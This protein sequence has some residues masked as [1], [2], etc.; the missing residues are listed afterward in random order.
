MAEYIYTN[1]SPPTRVLISA[2]LTLSKWS[3]SLLHKKI[4]KHW[5]RG[6]WQYCYYLQLCDHIS[7]ITLVNKKIQTFCGENSCML[8]AWFSFANLFENKHLI[9]VGSLKMY[10]SLSYKVMT[11]YSH[12]VKIQKGKTSSIIH[13]NTWKKLTSNN[14]S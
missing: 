8:D 13:S 3:L 7:Y 1:N 12:L 5:K 6:D 2:S 14:I 4:K 10:V 11:V 9:T